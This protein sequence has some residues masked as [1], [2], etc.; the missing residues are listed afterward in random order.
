MSAPTRF[1]R[2]RAAFGTAVTWGFIWFGILLAGLSVARL[3]GVLPANASWIG[4]VSFAVR[5]GV[6]GG[7]AGG[8]FAA[9]IGLVYQG[10]RLSDISWV[11]FALGGGIATAVFVPLFLQFMNVA[12]GGPPVAWGLLT[13]DMVLT[14]VL[15]AVA[16]GTMLKVAQRAE[17]TLP[18]RIREKPEL[19][20]PPE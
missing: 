15:G 5:A 7:V 17:T 16:A 12:T 9:F 8:A 4:I 10:K 20:G 6:I 11:R 3:A 14:G 1:R 2:L 18:G 13:D 19:V